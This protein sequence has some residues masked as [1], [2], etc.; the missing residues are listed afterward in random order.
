MLTR[1][2]IVTLT[3][4]AVLAACAKPTAKTSEP[5]SQ[6]RP[7][8]APAPAP[9]PEPEPEPEPAAAPEPD[10][11]AKQ[12][13]RASIQTYLPDLQAC[14]EA[15]LRDDATLAGKM[16]YTITIEPSGEVSSV[17]IESDTVDSEAVS[18]CV[19]VEIGSWIFGQQ[20]GTAASEVTFSAKF[21]AI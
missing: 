8:P 7:T 6:P 13:L 11:D 15:A 17:V 5:E 4:A 1:D 19:R 18:A 2:W 20:G 21:V 9:E 14:Y 12:S 10:A 16:T 3:V